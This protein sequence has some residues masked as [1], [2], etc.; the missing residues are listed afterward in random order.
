M[1]ASNKELTICCMCVCVTEDIDKLICLN[2][3]DTNTTLNMRRRNSLA[4]IIY[5]IISYHH[6]HHAWTNPS[7][8]F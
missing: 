1:Y 2:R 4:N 7:I 5:H 3:K 8:S 6:Y